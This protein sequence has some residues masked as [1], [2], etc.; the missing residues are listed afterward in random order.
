MRAAGYA[1][2]RYKLLSLFGD[3]GL[4]GA[5]AGALFAMH[6]GFVL[7]C[8]R[9]WMLGE[10]MIMVVLGGTGTWSGRR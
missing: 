3:C 5:I 8:V 4:L 2:Q 10:G 6:N 1:T 7:L 9:F